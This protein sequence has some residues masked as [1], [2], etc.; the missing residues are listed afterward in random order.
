[1]RQAIIAC[2]LAAVC[3]SI[4]SMSCKR[5]RES[6]QNSCTGQCKEQFELAVQNCGAQGNEQAKANCQFAAMKDQSACVQKCNED[7]MK[8]VK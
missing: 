5:A 1:M 8:S 6:E 3:V 7:F 2:T 4:F